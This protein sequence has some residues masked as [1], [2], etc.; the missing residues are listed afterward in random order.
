[1]KKMR[2][3]NNLLP[4]FGGARG[5]F[6]RR[7]FRTPYTAAKKPRTIKSA[8]FSA[9]LARAPLQPRLCVFFSVA[10][11]LQMPGCG[12]STPRRLGQVIELRPECAAEY[13]RVHADNHA[14]VRDLLSKHGLTNFSI[15]MREVHGKLLLFLYGEYTGADFEGDMRRLG[16]EERDQ[17]WHRLCD[18]MQVSVS[19]AAGWTDMECVYYNK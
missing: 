9:R 2:E 10:A 7:L 6:R 12:P 13:T 3:K 5:K 15:F 17:E 11:R 14:G 8:A 18:P 4:E 16:A 19:G 1:M